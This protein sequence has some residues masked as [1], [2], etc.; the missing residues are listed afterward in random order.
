MQENFTCLSWDEQ[1]ELKKA[2]YASL[3]SENATTLEDDNSNGSAVSDCQ[4]QG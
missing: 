4:L 3:K 2:L 1:N